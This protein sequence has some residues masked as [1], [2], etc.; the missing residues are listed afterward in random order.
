MYESKKCSIFFLCEANC[1]AVNSYLCP[2]PNQL[3]PADYEL[4]FAE[5]RLKYIEAK[6]L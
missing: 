3:Q 5:E 2:L 4:L 6:E 1:P